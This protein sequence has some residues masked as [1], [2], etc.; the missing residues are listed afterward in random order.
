MR[1]RLKGES[2]KKN[3]VEDIN[4]VFEEVSELIEQSSTNTI[5]ICRMGGMAAILELLCAHEVDE[6]RVKACRIF[7]SCSQNN[8][9][10]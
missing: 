5:N 1:K 2:T 8:I 7:V 4:V 6:I 10:V 9:K 3:E